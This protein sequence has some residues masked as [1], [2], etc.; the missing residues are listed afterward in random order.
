MPHTESTSDSLARIARTNESERYRRIAFLEAVWEG[1]RYE[2][3]CRPSWWSKDVPLRE[4]A[5]CVVYPIARSAGNRLASLVFGERSFP[6]VLPAS[7]K[8][9][10]D[11]RAVLGKLIAAMLK[12]VHAPL[13]MRLALLQGLKTGTVVPLVC[14]RRGKLCLDLIPAKWCEHSEFDAS[15]DVSVLDVRY[16]YQRGKC[17]YWY[18]RTVSATADTTFAAAEVDE[19]GREPVWVAD[20]E[21]TYPLEMMP[22]LWHRNQPEPGCES[23]MDGN[24]LHE[25]LSDEIEALDFSLSQRHRNAQY[26]GEPQT[27]VT[28]APTDKPGMPVIQAPQGREAEVNKFSW[29][30]TILPKW[31]QG[32]MGSAPG[33]T[34]KKGPGEVWKLAPGAQAMMLESSGAGANILQGDAS[35]LRKLL[36]E[37]MQ[38]VMADAETIGAGDLSA[39][40]LTILMGP[41]LALADNLR[42]EYGDLL[43]RIV[44]KMLRLLTTKAAIEQGVDLD[45]LD[46]ARP[47][48]VMFDGAEVPLDCVW[49]EYFTPSWDE[50]K[51][52]IDAAKSATGDRSVLSRKSAVRLVAPLLSVDDVDA[53]VKAIETEE[54]AGQGATREL[55]GALGDRGGDRGA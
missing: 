36:L 44:Q 29:G 5:P 27:V 42:V 17:L 38:V 3:E 28:G 14:L 18:R 48:L 46:A 15:G 8:L 41:M 47:L 55:F 13:R 6:N 30:N 12:Q 31:M 50:T 11:N 35:E 40:A 9:T 54:A 39:R 21:Q 34:A 52:A 20:P 26:N 24:A 2:M 45:G 10:P 33:S 23:E 43:V 51:A 37:V 1:K 49:G 22:A 53:E 16:R 7:A 4:R 19:D 25:G 32:W